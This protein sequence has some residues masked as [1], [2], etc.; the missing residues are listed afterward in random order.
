MVVHKTFFRGV[1]CLLALAMSALAAAST[2]QPTLLRAALIVED[3]ARSIRFYELLGFRTEL[4]QTNPRRPEGN[5]FP[6]NAASTQTRLVIM[7]SAAGEG[8]RIGLVE[9]SKPTP[10]DNRVDA[11]RTGR[12][13]VVLVFDVA[14]AEAIHQRLQSAAVVI[15]EPP[16]VYTSKKT[17]ADGS[18]LR[19]KVFHV[20][21]PDGYLVELLEA[22]KPS[23]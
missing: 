5:H 9:F 3:A 13:D 18:P 20:R 19:G 7:A 8:G 12:G 16:Q 6:L 2:P 14:D 23:P 4:D 21:D 17:A 11:A 22:P 10:A 15:L 1:L